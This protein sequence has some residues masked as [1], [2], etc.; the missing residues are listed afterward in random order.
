M[1]LV[2]SIVLEMSCSNLKEETMHSGGN[3]FQTAIRT[4]D[5][6]ADWARACESDSFVL[7]TRPSKLVLKITE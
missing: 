1:S 2:S 4:N 7:Q 5:I 6:F 3:E